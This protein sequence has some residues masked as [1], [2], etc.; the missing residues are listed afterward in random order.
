MY[1]EDDK[2]IENFSHNT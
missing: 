1:E 2:C